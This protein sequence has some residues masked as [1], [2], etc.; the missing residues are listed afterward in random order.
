VTILAVRLAGLVVVEHGDRLHRVGVPTTTGRTA[1]GR[2]ISRRATLA[3]S[4]RK[5]CR[6]CFPTA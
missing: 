1:C 4:G 6:R 2:D 3:D 5:L